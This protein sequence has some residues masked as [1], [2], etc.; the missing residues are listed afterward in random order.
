MNAEKAI[1]VYSE[2]LERGEGV[3]N[4]HCTV[5]SN[6]FFSILTQFCPNYRSMNYLSLWY[7]ISYF[8]HQAVK[9]GGR[10]E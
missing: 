2:K 7:C 9:W 4:R 10:V 5:L 8:F 1:S 6:E 3:F